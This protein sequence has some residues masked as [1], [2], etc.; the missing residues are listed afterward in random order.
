MHTVENL[1]QASIAAFCTPSNAPVHYHAAATLVRCRWLEGIASRDIVTWVIMCIQLGREAMLPDLLSDALPHLRG[2]DISKV[3]ELLGSIIQALPEK[4][5][6]VLL[7]NETVKIAFR[8]I[9]KRFLAEKVGENTPPGVT[10]KGK[11]RCRQRCSSCEA[12]LLHVRGETY[13]D[14]GWCHRIPVQDSGMLCHTLDQ[15]HALSL[16]GI[17]T[18][19]V[20]GSD[21]KVVLVSTSSKHAQQYL[22]EYL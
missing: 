8:T 17:A 9:M 11:R 5:R 12:L 13:Q 10:W 3:P 7:G 22:A 2:W 14:A 6:P 21:A 18:W 1:L 15:L 20:Y 16:D 4:W 19:R